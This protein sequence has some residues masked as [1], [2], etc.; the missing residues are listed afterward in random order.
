VTENE[1]GRM[2]RSEQFK[3]CVYR[4]GELRESLVDLHSDPG[5]M[6]NLV[7]DAAHKTVLEKHRRFLQQWI[8]SSDDRDARTFA[9]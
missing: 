9:Y 2:L 4:D 7:T 3:Y 1:T 8:N 6:Q 5:E